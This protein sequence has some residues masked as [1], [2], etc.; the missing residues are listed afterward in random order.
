MRDGR[1]YTSK[2]K[3]VPTSCSFPTL[4]RTACLLTMTWGKR[5]P[6]G[7]KPVRPS[8]IDHFCTFTLLHVGAKG[9]MVELP[10]NLG[11]RRLFVSHFLSR[12][13]EAVIASATCTTV[14][15]PSFFYSPETNCSLQ[16]TQP[17]GAVGATNR[18]KLH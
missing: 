5:R 13:Y 7:S 17:A 9:V 14:D 15:T 3:K 12:V 8:T 1:G 6:L 4:R 10:F 16:I 11:G 18:K 2:N